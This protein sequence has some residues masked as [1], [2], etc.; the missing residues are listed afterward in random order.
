MD[1]QNSGHFKPNN[2]SNA[3][4]NRFQRDLQR[5]AD[6]RR[7]T[8]WSLGLNSTPSTLRAVPPVCFVK[9]DVPCDQ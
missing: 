3:D 2:G 5:R 6:C 7:R 1:A 4:S 9:G 8:L